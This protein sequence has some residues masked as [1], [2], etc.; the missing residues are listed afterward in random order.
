MAPPTTGEDSGNPDGDDPSEVA[1]ALA[2]IDDGLAD[3]VESALAGRSEV[4][5]VGVPLGLLPPVL[6]ARERTEGDGAW[7]VACRPGVADALGRAFVLGTEVAEAV[8]EGEIELRTVAKGPESERVLFATHARV[9]A[10]AG[11]EGARTLVAEEAPDRVAPAARAVRE[12]YAAATPA[13]VG[14]PARSRLL[15]AARETLDD[16]FADDVAAA[17]DALPYG[18]VGRTGEVTDRTLLVAMAAR[19]DHLLWD[20]RRWIGTE[21]NSERDGGSGG[22]GDGSGGDEANTEGV[23]IAAGQDLTADRRALVRRDL[24]ESLKMPAGDGRP[25]LRLRAVDDALLRARPEEV[26]SVLRGRFALPLDADGRV[27]DPGRDERR[28]VWARRRRDKN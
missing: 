18:A 27:R 22:N 4:V 2:E 14:M 24:I 5:A 9:D 15:A 1:V 16:R 19:H 20:L 26:L 3:A 12:R 23:G 13:T 11:P 25:Q 8:A 7:R 6:A 10:V 28:P 17:L 21:A